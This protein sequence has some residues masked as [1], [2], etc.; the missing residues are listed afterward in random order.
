MYPKLKVSLGLLFVFAAQTA[1]MSCAPKS[2][3]A[4]MNKTYKRLN[5]TLKFAIVSNLN[6]TVKVIFPSN[7]M[8]DFN[9]VAIYESVM[10]KIHRFAKTLNKYNKTA[11]LINGHS[12][13]IGEEQYNKDLS[14]KRADTAKRALMRYNVAPE[15]MSTWGMGMR[16]PI[17]D[18]QTEEG[19]ARNRRVEFVI[20]YQA[21]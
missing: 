6:D 20:L 2:K 16:H 17:A 9:S 1:L 14:A 10:P 13:N 7:L 21:K 8:F 4:Y 5:R 3:K 12:D 18:N 19:R 11:I 15:R